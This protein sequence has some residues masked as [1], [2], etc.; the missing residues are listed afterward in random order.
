MN[1]K[2]A[3]NRALDFNSNVLIHQLLDH[4]IN[5][6]LLGTEEQGV[7]YIDQRNDLVRNKEAWVD[8]FGRNKTSID[9]LVLYVQLEITRALTKPIQ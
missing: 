2:K 9:E 8:I 3:S 6:F 1:T 7:V 5:V 4:F